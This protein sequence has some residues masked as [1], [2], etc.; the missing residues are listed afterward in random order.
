MSH[1]ETTDTRPMQENRRGKRPSETSGT[2]QMKDL[3]RGSN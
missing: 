2:L 3:G 1:H